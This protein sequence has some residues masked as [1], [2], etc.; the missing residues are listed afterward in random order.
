MLGVV[1]GRIATVIVVVVIGVVH[2]IQRTHPVE[3]SRRI[4]ASRRRHHRTVAVIVEAVG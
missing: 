2:R 1:V 3:V 4:A